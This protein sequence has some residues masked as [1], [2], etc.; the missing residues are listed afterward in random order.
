MTTDTS[1]TNIV[2]C[3]THTKN[4][5][6]RPDVLH[7][8]TDVIHVPV[9]AKDSLGTAQS[10]RAFSMN[11]QRASITEAQVVITLTIMTPTLLQTFAPPDVTLG[12]TDATRAR[13]P[14]K[15]NSVTARF[16][17]VLSTRRPNVS[18]TCAPRDV[19]H[20][21]TAA[22]PVHVIPRVRWEHAR[23]V[24]AFSKEMRFVPNTETKER[25]P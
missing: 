12:T 15:A 17:S 16:G 3:Q 13:A 11:R 10:A 8:T 6:V 7:G 23:N 18:T 24:S 14:V 4:R 20:G 2:A 22:T 19:K 5:Y 9:T 1:W 21:T 25:P